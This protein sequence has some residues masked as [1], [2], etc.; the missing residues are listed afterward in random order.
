MDLNL[1]SSWSNFS[2]PYS[3]KWQSPGVLSQRQLSLCATHLV[4]SLRRSA[5]TIPDITSTPP[6]SP[7]PNPNRHLPHV[8]RGQQ[9][10]AFD[11]K[12]GIGGRAIHSNSRARAYST[13][14]V[15][16]RDQSHLPNF[17]SAK[18]DF[19]FAQMLTENRFSGSDRINDANQVSF[20]RHI[21]SDRARI[22]ARNGCVWPLVSN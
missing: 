14:Y 20:A 1:I 8:Q 15:P 19:S 16:F 7:D 10:H 21:A 12:D 9:C 6:A 5:Y 22:R 13:L 18:T 17:D 11:R 2:H 4:T 3:N